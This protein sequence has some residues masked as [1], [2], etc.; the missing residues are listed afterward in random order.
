MVAAAVV[1]LEQLA[2]RIQNYHLKLVAAAP[3][4]TS[5]IIKAL[6]VVAAARWEPQ[7]LQT[8]R[9]VAVAALIVR[10]QLASQTDH[11]AAAALAAVVEQ[12]P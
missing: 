3:N 2:H 7:A 9:F 11:F 4:Q 6:V 12:E 1:A 10:V 5:P 8:Y